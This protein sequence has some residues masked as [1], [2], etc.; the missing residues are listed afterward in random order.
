MDDYLKL[1]K[2]NYFKM[3]HLVLIYFITSHILSFFIIPMI[4]FIK[5]LLLLLFFFSC[6][7]TKRHLQSLS[8]DQAYMVW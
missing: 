1:I 4:L 8:N 7:E 6:V 3:R 2:N 5:L